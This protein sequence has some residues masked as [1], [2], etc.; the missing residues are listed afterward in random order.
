MSDVSPKCTAEIRV[1]GGCQAL[2]KS[3]SYMHFYGQ[4]ILQSLGKFLTNKG[5]GNLVLVIYIT[6]FR[7]Y[8]SIKVIL[9]IVFL[10]VSKKKSQPTYRFHLHVIKSYETGC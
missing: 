10:G 5:D 1:H 6:A 4:Q 3:E 9:L 2:C 7:K 8:K